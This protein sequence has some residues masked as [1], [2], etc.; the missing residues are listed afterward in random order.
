MTNNR[1]RLMGANA[2][3]YFG[4]LLAGLGGFGWHVV[5]VFVALF[6]LWLVILRPQELPRAR[7][8]WLQSETL[9]ALSTRAA[10]QIL[11]VVLCFGIGRGIGGVL[12]ALPHFPLML[13]IALS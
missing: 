2:L 3:L 8:E 6:L 12:G 10:V 11:L 1:Q 4:P 7:A 9:V 5:P 13:P